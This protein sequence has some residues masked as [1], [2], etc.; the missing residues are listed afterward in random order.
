[1]PTRSASCKA[2]APDPGCLPGQQQFP[3]RPRTSLRAF[4]VN[5]SPTDQ[6]RPWLRR[7]RTTPGEP[8][9]RPFRRPEDALSHDRNRGPDAPGQRLARRAQSRIARTEKRRIS[10]M[11]VCPDALARFAVRRA[12]RGQRFNAFK[13]VVESSVCREPREDLSRRERGWDDPRPNDF[14]F[15][16]RAP[17]VHSDMARSAIP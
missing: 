17:R 16:L 2:S 10:P 3:V 8:G 13:A 15:N 14:G 1:M 5:P 7:P 12:L 11:R 6:A 9:D 4:P